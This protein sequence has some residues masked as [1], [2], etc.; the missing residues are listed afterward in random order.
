MIMSKEKERE[1]KALKDFSY[2]FDSVYLHASVSHCGFLLASSTHRLDA[3]DARMT[4][5][6]YSEVQLA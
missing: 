3:V 1:R 2:V 4:C 6:R 5:K